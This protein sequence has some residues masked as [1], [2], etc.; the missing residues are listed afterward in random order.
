MR[1]F[2]GPQASAGIPNPIGPSH[3]STE[4]KW[5]CKNFHAPASHADAR[6][7]PNTPGVHN[8]CHFKG[9]GFRALGLGFWVLG[10]TWFGLLLHRALFLVFEK[11]ISP[12]TTWRVRRT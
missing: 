3:Y 4:Q 9:L 2:W 1:W 11:T 6:R 5:F 8:N 12:N 10:F 7:H